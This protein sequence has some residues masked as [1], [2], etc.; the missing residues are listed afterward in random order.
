MGLL[1]GDDRRLRLEANIENL[2][3]VIEASIAP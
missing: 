1:E 2:A 3:S